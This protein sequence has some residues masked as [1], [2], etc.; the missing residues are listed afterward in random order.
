V[1]ALGPDQTLYTSLAQLAAQVQAA[2]V[3]AITGAVVGDESRYD[4][5]RTVPTW[6]PAYAA[7][8]DVG[9]LSALDV[10]DGA[11]ASSSAPAGAGASASALQAARSADPAERAATIFTELL[12]ADGVVVQRSP[13]TGTTP[14]ATPVLSTISSPPLA[15]QV[16]AMLTVSDD[17]AAELLTKEL[18]YEAGGSGTTAAGV[19]AIRA[20][21]ARDGLPVAQVVLY[22]GSG[23]DRT[24]R[25]TCGFLVADLQRLGAASVVG[26]G[27]PV[28]ARTGTLRARLAGTPAAGR[29]RAKTGTLNNVSSLSGFVLPTT[30]AAVP[31]TVLGQPIVFSLIVNGVPSDTIGPTIGDRVGVALA[32]YPQLPALARIE[33]HR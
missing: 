31:G 17:T 25:L 1:A 3:R 5:L 8:G 13:S 6:S 30:G 4:S 29:L 32:G 14:A 9:P 11:A 27:L 2:G 28:A 21:L 24:D 10:N 20:D 18:G 19:T 23:L 26:R 12:R 33:P 7:E 15:Q 22:D 16:Q